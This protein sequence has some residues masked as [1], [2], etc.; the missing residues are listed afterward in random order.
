MMDKQF[1]SLFVLLIC[2]LSVAL[3]G[4]A[5]TYNSVHSHELQRVA[6][7]D[8]TKNTVIFSNTRKRWHLSIDSGIY[9]VSGSDE[10]KNSFIPPRGDSCWVVETNGS[11]DK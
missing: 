9:Y 10:W 11:E 5:T 2:L 1:T 7:I 4:L 8:S 6:C 3:F